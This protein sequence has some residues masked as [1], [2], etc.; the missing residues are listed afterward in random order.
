MRVPLAFSL[1][2]HA[3][4]YTPNAGAMMS[5]FGNDQQMFPLSSSLSS[6]L[7]G[8]VPFGNLI[9]NPYNT[10]KHTHTLSLFL[11]EMISKTY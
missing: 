2:T 6:S 5:P 4:T 10:H 7:G 11:M 8:S 3:H 9:G 1:H